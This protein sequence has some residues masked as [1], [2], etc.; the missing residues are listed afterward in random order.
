[1]KRILNFL[2]F[3][4]IFIASCSPSSLPADPEP[5]IPLD[6]CALTSPSGDQFDAQ[7][8]VLTLPEDRSNPDGRKIEV[9]IAVIP[10]IKRDP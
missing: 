6:D 3:S 10:A 7:C 4:L 5:S 1:M 2:L 8:G 9:H